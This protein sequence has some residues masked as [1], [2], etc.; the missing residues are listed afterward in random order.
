MLDELYRFLDLS[1]ICFRPGGRT[2]TLVVCFLNNCSTDTFCKDPT[3]H[4]AIL[5]PERGID[6][7]AWLFVF[8]W[9]VEE[10]W[11]PSVCPQKFSFIFHELMDCC[12]QYY[13]VRF[14]RA[15]WCV[16]HVR[17]CEIVHFEFASYSAFVIFNLCEVENLRNVPMTY[18]SDIII[19]GAACITKR[20]LKEVFPNVITDLCLQGGV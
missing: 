2:S 15:I 4:T 5:K 14:A 19:V 17:L 6:S 1:R 12:F 18:S 7:C 9:K 13:V 10:T 8:L 3:R 20:F 16:T 11:S